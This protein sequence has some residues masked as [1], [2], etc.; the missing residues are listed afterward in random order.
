MAFL[1]GN[2]APLYHQG[3][4]MRQDHLPGDVGAE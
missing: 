4:K 2:F 1:E 3:S